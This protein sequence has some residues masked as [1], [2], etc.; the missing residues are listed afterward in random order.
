MILA[1]VGIYGLVSYSVTQRTYEI[2]V[3]M[4]IGATKG[5]VVAMIL[6]QSLKV[7]ALG[8][9]TG[10]AAAIIITRFLSS[11]LFGVAATD[12]FTFSSVTALLLGV[13]AAASCI[14]AWRAAQ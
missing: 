12:P 7:A 9:G 3:R 10:I 4:A 6:M 13:T 14:P 2:G 1:A 8:I 11:L 5:S